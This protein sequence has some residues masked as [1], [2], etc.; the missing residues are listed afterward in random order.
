MAGWR[1]EKE[2]MR[3]PFPPPPEE[4]REGKVKS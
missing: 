3:E 4:R 1:F 2:N